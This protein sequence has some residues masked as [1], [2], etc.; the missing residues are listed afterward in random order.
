M[1]P[2]RGIVGEVLA[3]LAIVMITAS[4]MLTAFFLKSHSNQIERLRGLVGHALVA[5][6]RGPLV[7]E[8]SLSPGIRWWWVLPSGEAIE[9]TEGAGPLDEAGRTV[10]AEARASGEPLLRSGPPWEPVRFA[11]RLSPGGDVVVARLPAAV[12]T[13]AV[14]GL[15]LANV[16]VFGFFG[17][18]LL[19]RG[20]IAPLRRLA[21]AAREAGEG[22]WPE[23]VPVDGVGEVAEVAHAFNEMGEA[24]EKRTGAL[25]KAVVELRETNESL[26]EARDGLARAD[27][28]AAVGRLAAGVAHEVGNPMGALL[29]F[30]DL[31]GRE[32]GLSDKGRELLGRA[33]AE[34]ERVRT[35]LRR[36]L[37]FSRPPRAV[38]EPV[39]PVAIA[40]QVLDLIR[41]QRRYR[42]IDLALDAEPG[43][44]EVQSDPSM[45]MQI[46]LNLVLN[47]ADAVCE[48]D[49]PRIEVRV[50]PA[51]M[52][53]RAGEDPAAALGRRALDALEVV[54][55]DNGPG[56]AEEDRGRIFDPFFTTKP[57]GE[58]TG[59]GLANAQSLAD[60]LGASLTLDPTGP[61]A[62]FVL[63]LP[64]R[65]DARSSDE[66]G[67]GGPQVRSDRV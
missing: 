67:R 57:P 36:L 32:P 54:V 35:T 55:A 2:R 42:R 20:V 60:Q 23:R 33:S 19:G 3:S 5:Q 27:R 26:R 12:P 21:E 14:V 39:E 16:L 51:P 9:K 18:Y 49:D 38:S 28:Q 43:L 65:S 41:P 30:L 29:A 52:A 8:D 6:A 44:P 61:G 15:L 11:V 13:A 56:I 50:R 46:L 31:V 63:R 58:G 62:A 47:A 64:L 53:V 4:A 17:A 7:V 24:L 25:E 1:T 22:D 45:L 37:D 48:A 34:G 40:N 10:A 59:L 66:E